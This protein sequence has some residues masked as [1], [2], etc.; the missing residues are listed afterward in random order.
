MVR[1]HEKL[2]KLASLLGWPRLTRWQHRIREGVGDHSEQV[3]VWYD[4]GSVDDVLYQINLAP[5]P[6]AGVYAVRYRL[7]TGWHRVRSLKNS[8]MVKAEAMRLEEWLHARWFTT[9]EGRR[10]FRRLHPDA[11]GWSWRRIREGK[12][13]TYK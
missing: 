7:C 9:V 2:G 5:W 6:H 3:V 13:P 1:M 10:A 12:V 8:A 4:G 11:S